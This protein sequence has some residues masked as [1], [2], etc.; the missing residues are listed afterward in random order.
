MNKLIDVIRKINITRVGPTL[1]ITPTIESRPNATVKPTK[2]TIKI[3]P[4][5]SGRPYCC[6]IVE[7]APDTI[8]T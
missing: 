3:P 4:A 2:A 8:T 5:I 7:A 6:C 1:L